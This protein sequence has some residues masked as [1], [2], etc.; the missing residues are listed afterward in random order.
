MFSPLECRRPSG[1]KRILMSDVMSKRQRSSCM[2][3]IRS[4]G[5]KTTELR[6]IHVFRRAKLKGW[7]RQ[8]CLPGKP[9][10]VFTHLKIALFVD[11]CFWHG[12]PTHGQLPR[13]N[14]A[15]WKL[16]LANNRRRDQR[17]KAILRSRGWKVL[18][19]WEHS[20]R[21]EAAGGMRLLYRPDDR[22]AASAID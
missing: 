22:V 16:K 8:T 14:A 13:Q 11:G 20:L 3:R 5:N 17:V 19:F 12:C 1:I 7:R 2:S 10:F 6:L 15:Y 18:R 9:D 4:R 21:D